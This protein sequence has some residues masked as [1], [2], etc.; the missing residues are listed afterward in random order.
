MAAVL[1]NGCLDEVDVPADKSMEI[2]LKSYIPSASL[3]V[4]S[5]GVDYDSQVEGGLEMSIWR[6]DEGGSGDVS[7]MDPLSANLSGNPDPADEW[8]RAIHFTPA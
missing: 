5:E 1:L 4:K 3:S 7:T 6:W 2:V 8:K